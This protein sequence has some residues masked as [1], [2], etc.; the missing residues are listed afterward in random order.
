MARKILTE[1]IF[2]KMYDDYINGLSAL[3][4]SEKYNF[5]QPTVRKHF[6]DRNLY[7]STS[8]RFDKD[9]LENIIFDYK[10]GMK[11]YELEKKYNRR[12]G[13]IIEKLRSIISDK[14]G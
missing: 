1:D 7:F 6:N 5:N 13:T 11:P 4:I 10:N 3:E 12:S 2:N 9:E 14:K 8:K